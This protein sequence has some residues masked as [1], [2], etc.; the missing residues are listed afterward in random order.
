MRRFF[1]ASR[2]YKRQIGY[3]SEKSKIF[4]K[5]DPQANSPGAAIGDGIRLFTGKQRGA[6]KRRANI[7]GN[8]A[9]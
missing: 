8:H 7:C 3:V 4:H 2:A 6:A 5:C 9:R 1:A